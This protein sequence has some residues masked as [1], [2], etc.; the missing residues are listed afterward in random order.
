VDFDEGFAGRLGA[1]ALSHGGLSAVR[2][3]ARRW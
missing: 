1:G 2:R 3:P